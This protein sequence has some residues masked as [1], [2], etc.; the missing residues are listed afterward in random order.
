MNLLDGQM[1]SQ[2]SKFLND[3][4]WE[5]KSSNLLNAFQRVSR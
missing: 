2:T 4:S 1:K 5:K 3:N